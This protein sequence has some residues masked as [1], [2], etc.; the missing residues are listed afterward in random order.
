M[1]D[2]AKN[3]F[4]TDELNKE[5]HEHLRKK[6]QIRGRIEELT[7]EKNF[8]TKLDPQDVAHLLQK[9]REAE[10]EKE[11]QKVEGILKKKR[12]PSPTLDRT[13]DLL[14]HQLGFKPL[15]DEE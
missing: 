12:D 6:E 5:Y 3:R 4:L 10:L 15:T 8:L 7:R 2:D 9:R 1:G 11:H 13:D 14:D